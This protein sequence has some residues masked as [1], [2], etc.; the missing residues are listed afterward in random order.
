[1]AAKSRK[2]RPNEIAM[3]LSDV[4]SCGVVDVNGHE[5][6]AT[7][8]AAGLTAQERDLKAA[9]AQRIFGEQVSSSAKRAKPCRVLT[10]LREGD[11]LTWEREI[12]LERQPVAKSQRQLP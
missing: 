11:V 12:M 1:M 3:D 2:P 6:G 10:F 9:G 7:E 5:G 8:Q 4:P